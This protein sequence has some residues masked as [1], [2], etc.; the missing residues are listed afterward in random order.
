MK[1]HFG[2]S[3]TGLLLATLAFY[4]LGA[5]WYGA[6]FSEQWMALANITEEAANANME[7]LG[8]MM[9]ILGILITVVQVIGIATVLNWAKASDLMSCI[10]IA[11]IPAV[12]FS[13]PVIAYGPLYEAM[14]IELLMIDFFHMLTGYIL[15]GG[16]LS[17]FRD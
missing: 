14:P 7:K 2:T 8:V 16:I 4:I 1:K 11:S 10:K 17:F 6:L 5:V 3:L 13:L 15:V 9:W 12:L